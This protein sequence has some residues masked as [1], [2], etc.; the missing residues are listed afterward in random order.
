[1]NIISGVTH[2][3]NFPDEFRNQH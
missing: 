2:H 3:A 1:M